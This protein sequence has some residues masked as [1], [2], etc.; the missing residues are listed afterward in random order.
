M[1]DPNEGTRHG[2]PVTQV[3]NKP[4]QNAFLDDIRNAGMYVTKQWMNLWFTS[5]QYVWG[6]QLQG[7][8]LKEDWEYTVVNRIYPLMFQTIS[9]LAKNHP[10]I[11]AHAWDD[12]QEGVVDQAENWAGHLQYLWESPY[13]LNMRLKL[14]R[15]LLD[16]GT[17]GYMVS[18]TMWNEKPKGGWDSKN[19]RWVGKTSQRFI[20]PGTFW[21]D[22]SAES[23][24]EAE[25]LG[26]I[27]R[28]KMEW[29]VNRWPE[30]KTK[31][32]T[33]AFTS[34]DP[35]YKVSDII[36]YKDQKGSS[37]E[38]SR[39][40]MFSK[41][42]D[43]ILGHGSATGDMA[44]DGSSKSSTQRYV[45]IEETYWRDYSE[46]HIEIE[47]SIPPQQMLD[48][49]LYT[50]E[51]TTG[52][53]IDNATGEPV[54]AEDWPKRTI[55]E[56]YEPQFP[57]GRFALRIGRTILNP[58]DEDQVYTE[59]KWPFNVMPYHILPHM[60]Q[61]G[62]AAEQSRN[63]ND[64]LNMTV[65]CMLNQ[66]RRTADPTR[67]IEAGALAR[68]R[69]GKVRSTVD[70]ITGIGRIVIAAKTKLAAIGLMPEAPLDP[71]VPALA[72]VMKQDID[73]QMFMQDVARGAATGGQQTKAE[74]VR[75]N[76][77][78]L[79]YASLQGVFL[80]QFIDDTATNIAE[81]CQGY[82]EP[83]RLMQIIA[84]DQQQGSVVTQEL[85][86]VRLIVN[87]EPG[88]TLPFDEEK[89]Q[90]EYKMAYELL[91]NPIPNPMIEEMLRILNISKRDEILSRYKGI[92][93]FRQF[94][95]LGQM[96]GQMA[97]ADP[98]EAQK[99]L[100][101]VQGIPVLSEVMQLMMQAAQL[102]PQMKG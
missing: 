41:M 80:D 79:D 63:N 89:K 102:A 50:K 44:G 1:M 83:G 39:K 36:T 101:K 13:E 67:L 37:L 32:E 64:V 70:D 76:A 66:V 90:I 26:T 97:Q 15:G 24:D 38:L 71:A 51:E 34:E 68:G 8:K 87:I 81:L 20:H 98:E 77:N 35:R 91:E 58:K 73:D 42:A 47:D 31:I 3:D 74:V 17:F 88:S 28:V 7:W 6:K 2:N 21:C 60:W 61:G 100:A 82:Y 45:N 96:V 5:I 43:I 14:I 92:Q 22:P 46:K 54:K 16:C 19:K 40:G 59:K 99:Q 62:N 78:S 56:Y 55:Q 95:Q 4:D 10:K 72:A 12:S 23:I 75:L 93:L 27:R 48:Q 84:G 29:A 52:I 18:K 11:L 57:N 65:S 30:Y 53:Y 33:E 86:D 49:G 9:K 25:N 69:D 94:I 85:L